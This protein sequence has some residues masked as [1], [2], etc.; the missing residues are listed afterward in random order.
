M[1]KFAI[2]AITNVEH[3]NNA[4]HSS[5]GVSPFFLNAGFHPRVPASLL[6]PQTPAS[7][8]FDTFLSAQQAALTAAR[9]ALLE[10]QEQQSKY[11]NEQRRPHTYNIGDEVLLNAEHITT[12][13]DASRPSSS[14]QARFFG[15]FTIVEQH[16][17]VS[18]R[19]E[20]PPTMRIHDVF[21]VDRFRPYRLSPE[22]LGS[23]VAPPPAPEM[24]DGVEEYVVKALLKHRTGRKNKLQFLVEWEGYGPHHASWEPLSGLSNAPELLHQYCSDNGLLHLIGEGVTGSDLDKTTSINQ[25]TSRLRSRKN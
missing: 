25:Q 10:A 24:I 11:A 4:I 5:T 23:R 19:L 20:L 17:P 18:F 9:D 15:P 6:S 22:S 2:H 7:T 21:H 13:Y 8:D 1:S 12:A 14:L 3:C 16:S